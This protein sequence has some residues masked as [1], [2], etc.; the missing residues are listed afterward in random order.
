M[1]VREIDFDGL[2]TRYDG[3]NIQIS[4]FFKES[5]RRFA[6]TTFDYAKQY[7]AIRDYLYRECDCKI[8]TTVDWKLD[9]FVQLNIT[10]NEE[11]KNESKRN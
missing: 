6:C 4:M 8:S 5:G 1:K 11:K 2:S 10:I 7:L 3:W 9:K